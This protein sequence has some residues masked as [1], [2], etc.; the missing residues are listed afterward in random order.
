[1]TLLQGITGPHFKKYWSNH[2]M[3]HFVLS[4]YSIKIIPY[5]TIAK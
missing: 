2:K 5:K 4:P 1:M 3:T